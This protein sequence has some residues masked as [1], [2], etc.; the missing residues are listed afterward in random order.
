MAGNGSE[1]SKKVK[2]EISVEYFILKEGDIFAAYCPAL[3]LAT[4]GDTFEDA[5]K[6][7]GEALQIFI[8]EVMEMG[9][10]DEVLRE[11]GWVRTDKQWIP[12]MVVG[13]STKRVQIP[14]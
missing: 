9:T 2:A 10:L 11:N 7:F 5:G 4:Q 6:A 14:G 13:Q 12:P 8:D 1:K 3:D